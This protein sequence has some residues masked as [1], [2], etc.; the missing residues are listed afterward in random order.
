[1][2]D[3][4]LILVDIQNDYFENGRWPVN[5]M[6]EVSEN[7]ARLLEHA[8]RK[9]DTIIHIHHEIP[10]DQAPFFQ[11]GTPGAEIHTSVNPI[12]GEL[13]ILKY[14]PNSFHNTSLRHDL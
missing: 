3:T 5:K 9:G 14:R 4:A 1:M 8:R 13:V 2:P 7:A 10:S 6:Q 11:P 12:E